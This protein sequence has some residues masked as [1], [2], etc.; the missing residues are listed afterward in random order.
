MTG[1]LIV[2]A[3][4]FAKQFAKL[5]VPLK[6]RV[7]LTV[8]DLKRR[9]AGAQPLESR[10][11]RKVAGMK[12][13]IWRAK[14]DKGPRMLF[15]WDGQRVVLL[16]VGAHDITGNYSDRQFRTDVASAKVSETAKQLAQYEPTFFGSD[17]DEAL[18]TLANEELVPEWIYYLDEEQAAVANRLGKSARQLL[19]GDNTS[20]HVIVG[21]PG[22]GKT[23]L[24]LNLLD[25]A[26]F[27]DG[28]EI[29]LRAQQQVL[30]YAQTG[31]TYSLFPFVKADEGGRIPRLV[32]IDDPQSFRDICRTA[33]TA[34]L[35]RR[36]LVVFAFD[37]LQL[38]SAITDYE[39][40]EFVRR[41]RVT[42][43]RLSSAYRQKAK[44][45][46]AAKKVIDSVA[47][48][49]PFLDENTIRVFHKEHSKL[50]CFSNEPVFRNPHGYV[51]WYPEAEVSHIRQELLRLRENAS[52][53]WMHWSPLLVV[54]DELIGGPDRRVIRELIHRNWSTRLLPPVYVGLNESHKIK[55][56]E[57]QHA[58]LFLTAK[59]FGEIEHGFRGSGQSTYNKRRLLRIP[60]TRAKDTLCTFVLSGQL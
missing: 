35:A 5:S 8:W 2:T 21:G 28:L 34:E 31:F 40:A 22:T 1:P 37:P 46:S 4:A 13:N 41:Y 7:H 20:I 17:P 39:Y 10:R 9:Y 23:S 18:D 6:T 43:H 16:S 29:H 50:T 25:R 47:K 19:R 49:T 48:S 12:A 42:E 24:L 56:T 14:L 30:E 52:L 58:L 51:K 15:H 36:Q 3:G 32:L 45:A 44:V 33:E 26:R 27:L 38:A 59:T 54:M 57:H 11:I 60:F 55:G 53:M